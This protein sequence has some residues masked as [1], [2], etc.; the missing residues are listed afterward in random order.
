M[1]RTGIEARA[2]SLTDVSKR[3]AMMGLPG[4][5]CRER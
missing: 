1:V 5:R 3:G 2:P 4:G